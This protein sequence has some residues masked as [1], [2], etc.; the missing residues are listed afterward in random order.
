LYAVNELKK[1][2]DSGIYQSL[3]LEK[4]I[5]A[6]TVEGLFHHNAVLKVDLSSPFFE[7]KRLVEQFEVVVMRHK[8][9]GVVSLGIDEFP[10]MNEKDI[11]KLK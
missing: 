5:S 1:L 11:E 8:E 10:K 3:K 2:S 7:S 4:V 9:D 6:Q